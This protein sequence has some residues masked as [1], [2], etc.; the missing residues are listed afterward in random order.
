MAV[1]QV[2]V[3]PRQRGQRGSPVRRRYSGRKWGGMSIAHELFGLGSWVPTDLSNHR[4]RY[5]NRPDGSGG[6]AC[7]D[8]RSIMVRRDYDGHGLPGGPL[9]ANDYE[10]NG[11]GRFRLWVSRTMSRGHAGP[12]SCR[13]CRDTRRPQ[14]EC[15]AGTRGSKP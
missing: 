10:T 6:W 5:L 15:R 12:R 9:C 8:D 11:P 14:G 13:G 1:N 2:R 4:T 7:S 3:V